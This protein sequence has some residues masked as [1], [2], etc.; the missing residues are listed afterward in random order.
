MA[1][2]VLPDPLRAPFRKLA[3]AILS[4]FPEGVV[5]MG[6]GSLLQ[7]LWRHRQ[8]T[9]LDLFVA[10]ANL[11]SAFDASRAYLY[12]TLLGALTAA[13]IE[14]YDD[15]RLM[16]RTTV[17][18]QGRC[19]NDTPWSL[20]DMHFMNPDHPMIDSVEGT[21]IRAASVTEIFMGKL[22]GR[23]HTRDAE[24]RPRIPVRDCYDICVCAAREPQILQ[25]IFEI[26]DDDALQRIAENFQNTP[27][28]LHQRDSKPVIEPRWS[29]ALDNIAPAIGE[30][31]AA[32]DLSR[33]PE[34]TEMR[35][36]PPQPKSPGWTP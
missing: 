18:L 17:F 3:N 31:I 30:A 25:R 11:S 23:A 7:A 5:A 28:D 1:D 21:G 6:G 24:E 33:L 29:I 15:Y 34:A 35:N 22:V 8:S 14:V 32:R 20:A 12:P 16:Q 2:L 19:E 36:V 9:D 27:P 4:A 10:P 26:L 13:D